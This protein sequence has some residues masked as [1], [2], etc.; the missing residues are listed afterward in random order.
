MRHVDNAEIKPFLGI[1]IL[2]GLHPLPT[3]DVYWSS[4]PF[5]RV[6]EIAS[7]MTC[8]RFKKV[9]ENI[10]LNDNSK[11]P[12]RGTPGYDKLY[13]VRP[14]LEMLNKACQSAAKTTTSQSIDESYNSKADRH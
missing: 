14:L 12:A 9:L 6:T 1:I 10:H 13:K 2:M 4:D 11:A 3:I 8:K 5:F 7:V